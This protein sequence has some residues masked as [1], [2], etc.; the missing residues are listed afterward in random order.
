MNNSDKHFNWGL[1][2]RLAAYRVVKSVD[3]GKMTKNVQD[4]IHL[5]V[6]LFV[7]SS[8]TGLVY[9]LIMI[10][11]FKTQLLKL[12]F[13]RHKTIYSAVCKKVY[14]ECVVITALTLH[15][16]AT[17]SRQ[18]N[19]YGNIISQN[20]IIHWTVL[21]VRR[22]FKDQGLRLGFRVRVKFW[23]GWSLGGASTC[24]K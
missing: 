15:L 19:L 20:Q 10:K 7:F 14:N 2:G 9:W 8:I 22:A 6:C 11:L 4:C 12:T 1:F 18:L 5:F 16:T 21:T 24:D 13:I 3:S 17:R 23:L